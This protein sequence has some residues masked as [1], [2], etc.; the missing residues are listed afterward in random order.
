MT[1]SSVTS[2]EAPTLSNIAIVLSRV[3]IR[4]DVVEVWSPNSRNVICRPT[5]S[6]HRYASHV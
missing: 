2:D 3:A 4:L 1:V 5:S 6:H